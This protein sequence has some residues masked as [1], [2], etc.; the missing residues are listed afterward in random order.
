[1][2]LEGDI[3]LFREL[4]VFRH[5]EPDALRLLAFSG[6][7]KFYAAG[8]VVAMSGRLGG[9]TLLSAGTLAVF[10]GPEPEGDPVKILRAPALVGELAMIA[11]IEFEGCVYACEECAA[12][13]LPRDTF[14]RVLQEY[15]RSAARI[16]ET[17]NERLSDLARLLAPLQAAH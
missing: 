11:P 1:M 17:L 12:L 8:D 3:R 6:E 15:P 2:A 9:G 13:Y 4:S 5:L 7:Q 16:R 10:P 14:R